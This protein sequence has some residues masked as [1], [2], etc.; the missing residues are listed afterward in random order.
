MKRRTLD[1]LACPECHGGLNL[2]AEGGNYVEHGNLHCT[3]CNKVYPIEKSIPHFIRSDE[4]TGLNRRFARAYD[5]V[6][7]L[8]RYVES[9]RVGRVGICELCLQCRCRRSYP[10]HNRWVGRYIT[11]DDDW[12]LGRGRDIELVKVLVECGFTDIVGK[13]V[14]KLTNEVGSRN[15]VANRL[16]KIIGSKVDTTGDDWRTVGDFTA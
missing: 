2:Q 16:R 8:Y 5:W 3:G 15:D 9:G 11:S 14:P 6:S 12:R 7:Y 10:R 1:L 13:H 4:L